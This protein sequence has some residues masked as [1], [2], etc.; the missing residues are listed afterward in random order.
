MSTTTTS[1]EET[2]MNHTLTVT[3][4]RTFP[5]AEY[6]GHFATVEVL[7]MGNRRYSV[8]G[9]TAEGKGRIEMGGDEVQGPVNYANQLAVCITAHREP[10]EFDRDI[11]VQWGDTVTFNGIEHRIEKAPNHNIKL[12]PVTDDRLSQLIEQHVQNRIAEHNSP[13]GLTYAEKVHARQTRSELARLGV[14]V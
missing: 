10:G 3:E 2:T 5:A 11:D 12:V 6:P 8:S 1:H 4:S 9:W 14:A 13:T 7:R